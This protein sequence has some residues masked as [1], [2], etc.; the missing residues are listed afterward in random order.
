MLGLKLSLHSSDPFTS[1]ESGIKMSYLLGDWTGKKQS[2]PGNV[3]GSKVWFRTYLKDEKLVEVIITSSGGNRH[4]LHPPEYCLTGSGWKISEKKTSK[5][6]FSNSKEYEIGE[7][8]LKREGATRH[9]IH[10][11]TDGESVYPD[12]LSMLAEDTF[13]RF[14]GEKNKLVF[15][16]NIS[17]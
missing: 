5:Y 3:Q 14:Q 16:Q 7:L 17:S 4:H 9:F 1:L 2:V 8:A 6:T 10:W 11:Y 12:Y 13:R 15:I